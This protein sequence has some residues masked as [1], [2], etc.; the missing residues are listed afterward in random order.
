VKQKN[1]KNNSHGIISEQFPARRSLTDKN[2]IFWE[3]TDP[4]LN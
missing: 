3:S 2:G 1:Q 4:S